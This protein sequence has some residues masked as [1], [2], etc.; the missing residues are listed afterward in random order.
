MVHGEYQLGLLLQSYLFFS[1]LC[2][3]RGEAVWLLWICSSDKTETQESGKKVIN[4][5]AA[6]ERWMWAPLMSE[7]RSDSVHQLRWMDG[8]LVEPTIPQV[9][10]TR[11]LQL[12][13]IPIRQLSCWNLETRTVF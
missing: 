1:I 2:S 11:H 9:K 6:V 10:S 5:L 7:W 4:R 13:R 8:S 3:I 12:A